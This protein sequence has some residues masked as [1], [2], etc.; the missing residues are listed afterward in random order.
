MVT[1]K[2]WHETKISQ[3]SSVCCIIFKGW[4]C[5]KSF[6]L[7]FLLVSR[8]EN[9]VIF[10]ENLDIIQRQWLL[11]QVHLRLLFPQNEVQRQIL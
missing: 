3:L 7:L 5:L 1:K 2:E 4:V 9:G 6:F 11:L 10:C 8:S